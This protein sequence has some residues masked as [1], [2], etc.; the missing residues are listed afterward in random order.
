VL[1]RRKRKV[2]ALKAFSSK[3]LG[4]EHENETFGKRSLVESVFPL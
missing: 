4:I 3:R 2:T 1:I